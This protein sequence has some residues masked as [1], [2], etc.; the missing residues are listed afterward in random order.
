M[1][2]LLLFW[3][4]HSILCPIYFWIS[5]KTK[6]L[7]WQVVVKT[8]FKSVFDIFFFPN[9]IM[10]MNISRAAL[11]EHLMSMYSYPQIVRET[12]RRP[13]TSRVLE[14]VVDLCLNTLRPC[15]DW[16][17]CTVLSMYSSIHYFACFTW[18]LLFFF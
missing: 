8:C 2:L 13:W 17:Y 1:L 10:K 14:Y 4:V 6:L 12:L 15:R 9:K 7:F 5:P 3:G 18:H 11:R 16:I